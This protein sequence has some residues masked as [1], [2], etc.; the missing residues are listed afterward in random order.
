MTRGSADVSPNLYRSACGVLAKIKGHVNRKW[1]K[2]MISPFSK[3]KKK[4]KNEQT[5]IITGQEMNLNT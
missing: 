5:Y 2:I 1:Q 4:E 3:K